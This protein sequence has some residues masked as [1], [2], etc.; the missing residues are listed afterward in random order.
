MRIYTFHRSWS[1]AVIPSRLASYGK[2]LPPPSF[3]L[4]TFAVFCSPSYF[5]SINIL[6]EQISLL[7][8]HIKHC[9]RST[10]LYY[11]RR[12]EHITSKQFTDF[13][14]FF[15]KFSAFLNS[16]SFFFILFLELLSYRRSAS[17]SPPAMFLSSV[18]SLSHNTFLLD[19]QSSTDKKLATT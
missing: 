11:G 3:I 4:L 17:L 12:I 9:R 2:S 6:W 19:V 5:L 7:A 18:S 1:S 15:C 14:V 10:A 8:F 13:S 16:C